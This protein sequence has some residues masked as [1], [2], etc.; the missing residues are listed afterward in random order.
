MNSILTF[1]HIITFI[2]SHIVYGEKTTVISVPNNN[3]WLLV[4]TNDNNVKHD[5]KLTLINLIFVIK[6]D[7]QQEKLLK[8]KF[9]N[10]S[11]PSCDDYAN[12][13]NYNEIHEQYL[14]AT[15]A[16]GRHV[17]QWLRS[18]KLQVKST[19]NKEFLIVKSTV[20]VIERIFQTKLYDY[21]HKITGQRTLRPVQYQLPTYIHHRVS[22]IVGF[23][24]YPYVKYKSHN[25]Q[26]TE[27]KSNSSAPILYRIGSGFSLFTFIMQ[28]VCYDDQYATNSLCNNRFNGFN[29]ILQSSTTK[30][31]IQYNV[32]VID[33][34]CMICKNAT[35]VIA[36]YCGGFGLADNDVLCRFNLKEPKTIPNYKAYTIRV[37][38][39]FKS[40][41]S[42]S[43]TAQ[44]P[45]AVEKVTMIT[46]DVL[47]SL[48]NVDNNVN[49]TDKRSRQAIV[50]FQEYYDKKAFKSFSNTYGKNVSL[51]LGNVYGDHYKDKTADETETSLDL[52]YM[53]SMGSHIP[54]DYISST[55]IFNAADEDF[56][57]FFVQLAFIEQSKQPLVYSISY[58]EPD[59]DLGLVYTTLLNIH[60]MKMAITGKTVFVSSGD[61]G[62]STDDK[63]YA[64]KTYML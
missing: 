4:T 49:N 35:P 25:S 21:E 46:P 60:F 54:T 31:L 45:S 37:R 56:I 13:L 57:G 5:R 17:E 59:T 63:L 8:Q 11:D 44:Y 40:P 10:V 61:T 23:D 52:Q 47:V 9:D 62:T 29:I 42:Y 58:G 3:N 20:D 38:T 50:G 53:A 39:I 12:Y 16:Y 64:N 7:E 1:L 51:V 41:N 19:R 6:N 48:Y 33:S 28:L 24:K 14:P 18:G 55:S 15:T 27:K 2:S 43:Q 30:Q 32:S 36:L 26:I 22:H 34:N